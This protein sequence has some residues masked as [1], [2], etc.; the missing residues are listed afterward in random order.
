VSNSVAYAH[1]CESA[2]GLRPTPELA[3]AR[4]LLLELERLYNHLNDIGAACAGVGFAPGAML[5]AA[6]KERAQRLNL[7]LTGHRFL[8]GTVAVGRSTLTIRDGEAADARR[9]LTALGGDA[10]TAWH[11]VLFNASVQDRF[12]GVGSLS[13]DDAIRAGSVGPVAR[14]SGVSRDAR[15]QAGDRL[16]Y[17]GFAP[18]ALR[19]PT[20]DVSSRVNQ[21]ALEV[22]ATLAMLDDL[23]ARPVDPATATPGGLAGPL[24]VGLVESPRGETACV[25]ETDGVS[26]TR[27]HL[28]TASLVNWPAL[29]LAATGQLFPDFPLINKSFELCY[30][31]TDR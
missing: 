18:A 6:L 28:R 17:P 8:F 13:R 5:F 4:T 9:E 15:L 21:R 25:V 16:H 23:L 3:R 19:H 30:A 1:A 7:L 27:L 20:G 29:A 22:D 2:L 31:C 11:E 10:R 26:V 24:G 14:A 12:V